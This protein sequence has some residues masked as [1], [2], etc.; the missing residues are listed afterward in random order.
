MNHSSPWVG[1]D[2][3]APASPDTGVGGFPCVVDVERTSRAVLTRARNA[4]AILVAIGFLAGSCS[5]PP[6]ES[7]SAGKPSCCLTNL[8]PSAPF[9]DK[10]LYQL[11]SIWTN[12]VGQSITLGAMRGR[13]QVVAM[14]FTRCTVACPI[15]V[16][17]L[18]RIEAA[19]PKDLQSK[20]GFGLVTL[21][22]EHDTPEAL[23]RYR[24]AAQLAAAQWTLLCGTPDDT[25]ELG[26]L[27][28][29]KFK[30]EVSGQFAHSNLITLLDE[31]G[32]IVYQIAG[33]NQD[34]QE[35]VTLIRRGVR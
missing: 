24:E 11:D 8:A 23:H 29:V 16:H 1:L 26:A 14:F 17:D 32:E 15:I 9:T 27:L 30:R 20:V 13:L 18:K 25:L 6:R 31:N 35:L 21:D 7:A 5:T 33:L 19:L 2:T 10:S 28:G 3:Q 34:I 4:V 22:T 12:D